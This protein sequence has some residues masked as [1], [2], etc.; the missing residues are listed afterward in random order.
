MSQKNVPLGEVCP[1]PKRTFFLRHPV[2]ESEEIVTLFLNCG[3]SKIKCLLFCP[4]V[5]ICVQGSGTN[6]FMIL[7]NYYYSFRKEFCN[8]DSA[9]L[10][11][12]LPTRYWYWL[13][14]FIIL[15]ICKSVFLYWSCSL[16]SS[17]L[18]TLL[19]KNSLL[20]VI[21]LL[22]YIVLGFKRID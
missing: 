7:N 1:S 19:L 16:P 8:V 2:L 22:Y 13:F 4:L 21:F 17:L 9:S 6:G 15:L 10:R 5:H 20:Y 14:Y 18:I 12:I 3:F 11:T